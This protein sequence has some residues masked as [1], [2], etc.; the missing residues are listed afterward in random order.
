MKVGSV[1][2]AAQRPTLISSLVVA[3]PSAQ[4]MRPPDKKLSH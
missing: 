1:V 3:V 4:R 2:T